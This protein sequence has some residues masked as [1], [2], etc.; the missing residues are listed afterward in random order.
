MVAS[1]FISACAEKKL[2]GKRV[3]FSGFESATRDKVRNSAE[4]IILLPKPRQTS[5]WQ[6]ELFSALHTPPHLNITPTWKRRFTVNSGAKRTRAQPLQ[7][8]P[9]VSATHLFSLSAKGVVSAF[10]VASGR[11]EWQKNLKIGKEKGFGGG[12]ALAKTQLGESLVIV[13]TGVGDVFALAAEDG[14]ILWKYSF[15]FPLRSAPTVSEQYIL[16]LTPNHRTLAL[17][18]DG[19]L[20]WQH[21]S[22]NQTATQLT[23]A[24]AAAI[25]GRYAII[26]YGDGTIF[27]LDLANGQALWKVNISARRNDALADLLD[28]STPPVVAAGV[29]YASSASGRTV[30]LDLASGAILWRISL[31][32]TSWLALFENT[33]FVVDSNN[34]LSA[35]NIKDGKVIWER[36]L[37]AN[38]KKGRKAKKNKSTFW[39]GP[40]LA[41][42][43]LIVN[44]SNGVIIT[45][46]A[47]DGEI[48]SKQ[49]FAS[50]F[51]A[52]PIAADN[53]IF[54]L[55]SK[56]KIQVFE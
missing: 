47:L 5:S 8:T 51:T 20:L 29:V 44:S 53:K 39:N 46:N 40:L 13:T 50:K 10:A 15:P 38:K 16:A 22:P 27:A 11:R 49:K 3:T 48:L 55:D 41:D 33:I 30:A 23:I 18:L 1:I 25:L 24:P 56:G 26:G 43:K 21:Q 42:G 34:I 2:P 7:A 19:E 45:L 4:Q 17:S 37:N 9:I 14:E 31:A 28:I 12:L 54:L 36:Q 32:A 6:Q 35:L 52:S